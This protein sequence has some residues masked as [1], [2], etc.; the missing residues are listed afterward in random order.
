[1]KTTFI[2]A[3]LFTVLSLGVVPSSALAEM[4]ADD[5][6][7][8]GYAK[9]EK[10][11][12]DGA[13]ADYSR[14]LELDPKDAAA[15]NNR[16]NVKKDKGDVD[17][18]IADYSRALELDPKF[19]LAY[20]NRGAMHFLKRNWTGALSDYRHRC[21]LDERNQ[22]GARVLIWLI[23]ARLGETEAA[24]KEL[25]A[26]IEKRWNTA[27]GDWFSHVAG[28]LL[29]KVS[30][31]DLF[32]AGK[33]PV[34]SV[35]IPDTKKERGQLCQAWFYSGMKKLLAGDKAAAT[36]HLKKCLA[37]EQKDFIEY[38]FAEAELKAL[39]SRRYF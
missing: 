33:T 13:I 32:A 3:L 14:A 6:L 23:R 15:Y 5:Y 30:E 34:A 21:E 2:N 1:M 37:T 18:A 38:G 26:L 25:A 9:Y 19:P 20:N 28:H 4:T 10:G 27:P 7:D 16:G 39:A 31:A 17:G 29:G 8:R 35:Q 36:E 12:P 22:D 24:D 11:D